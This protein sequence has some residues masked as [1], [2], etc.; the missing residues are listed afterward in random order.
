M[1]EVGRKSLPFFKKAALKALGAVRTA[2]ALWERREMLRR[3]YMVGNPLGM[4]VMNG[5]WGWKERREERRR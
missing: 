2:A 4:D 5:G 1:G 3:A